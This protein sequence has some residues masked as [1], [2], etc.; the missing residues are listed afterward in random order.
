LNRQ[1]NSQEECTLLN[2][3][4]S[5]IWL[6]CKFLLRRIENFLKKCHDLRQNLWI[7]N[8]K[9]VSSLQNLFVYSMVKFFFFFFCL[10]ASLLDNYFFEMSKHIKIQINFI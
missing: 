2:I 7:L 3:L 5:K 1:I 8:F 9:T 10:S 6:K 4:K